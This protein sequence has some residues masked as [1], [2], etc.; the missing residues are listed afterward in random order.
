[1]FELNNNY[2]ITTVEQKEAKLRQNIMNDKNIVASTKTNTLTFISS[3][4]DALTN[5]IKPPVSIKMAN[6]DKITNSFLSFR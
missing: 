3:V 5:N 6:V 1:M 4:K 2:D